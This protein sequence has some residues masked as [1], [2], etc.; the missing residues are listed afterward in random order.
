[1]ISLFCQQLRP[2]AI[3]CLDFSSVWCTHRR[4]VVLGFEALKGC[5]GEGS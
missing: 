4:G 5:F 3:G 1:M 2:Q